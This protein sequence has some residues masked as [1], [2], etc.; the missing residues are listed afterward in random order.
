MVPDPKVERLIVKEL[1]DDYSARISRIRDFNKQSADTQFDLKANLGIE[2]LLEEG[3]ILISSLDVQEIEGY[4][5]E[6]S[7]NSVSGD[8]KVSLIKTKSG[9]VKLHF[10]ISE[11]AYMM[12]VDEKYAFFQSGITKTCC[13]CLSS[14]IDASYSS[15]WVDYTKESSFTAQ[16]CM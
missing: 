2:P 8:T 3:D 14:F 15:A 5:A 16:D 13:C 4:P 1:D 6:M 12:R 7:H 11:G 10:S 9:F